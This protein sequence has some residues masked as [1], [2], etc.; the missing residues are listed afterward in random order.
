MFYVNFHASAA[1][2]TIQV[3]KKIKS[4]FDIMDDKCL[5]LKKAQESGGTFLMFFD[6]CLFMCPTGQS[7]DDCVCS[8]MELLVMYFYTVIF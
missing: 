7:S 6:K 8:S 4:Y 3:V 1:Y 2:A 5:K